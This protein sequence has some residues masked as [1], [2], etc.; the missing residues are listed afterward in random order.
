MCIHN[1]SFVKSLT[2]FGYLQVTAVR[3]ATL[4]CNISTLQQQHSCKYNYSKFAFFSKTYRR[5]L[6]GGRPVKNKTRTLKL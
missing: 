5:V 1:G 3:T 6:N 2:P 4:I